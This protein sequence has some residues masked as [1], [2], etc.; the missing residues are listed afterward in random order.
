MGAIPHEL[1]IRL[2]GIDAPEVEQLMGIEARDHLWSRLD[3]G[4]GTII[5]LPIETDRYG[6]TVAEL[7]VQGVDREEEIHINSQMTYDGYAYHDDQYSDNCPNTDAI[8]KGEE[9]AKAARTGVWTNLKAVQPWEYRQQSKAYE[10]SDNHRK[11]LAGILFCD[12]NKPI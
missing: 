8:A 10:P 3:Q 2:C 7:F 1:K 11:T 9:I 5:G 4:D 6:R 12:T